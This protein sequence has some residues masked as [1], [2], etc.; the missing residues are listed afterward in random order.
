M[1]LTSREHLSALT[2]LRGLAALWVLL[3]H[4]TFG[5][6]N[7]YLPGLSEKIEWGLLRNVVIQGVYA[8]DIFF[9]LSG[10]ILMH[11]HR[12][13]FAHCISVKNALDFYLLRLAR[14]YPVHLFVLLL[15]VVAHGTGIWNQK[16]FG[17]GEIALS[18][19][20]LN[21]WVDPSINTPAWSV[22]A[23]WFAYLGFP[24]I[25][26][27]LFRLQGLWLLWLLA[28]SLLVGYPLAVMSFQWTW[29]WHFGWVALFRVLNGF[30]LGCVIYLI[31]ER[32]VDFRRFWSLPRWSGLP[33]GLL[34]VVL[35]LGL[36]IVCV[37]PLIPFLIVALAHSRGGVVDL[38]SHKLMVILG[39]ISYSIYMVHY[40]VL[41]IFQYALNDVYV[42]LDPANHQLLLWM[43]LLGIVGTVTVVA[44]LMYSS[45]E[46]PIREYCKQIV[47]DRRKLKDFCSVSS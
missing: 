37:Y 30:V 34:V 25:T 11:V 1:Q 13:E 9:I 3:F 6:P 4:A 43:H 42:S 41:E 23:E 39:T 20:L 10:Y 28:I 8:V 21:M 19:F 26:F 14:I 24:L 47:S 18:F 5:G 17:G 40:P 44:A 45:V 16:L 22:S 38:L 7:G 27:V 15:L 29:E 36:P 35:I 2:G 31:Q 32:S 12:L 33:I 46:K